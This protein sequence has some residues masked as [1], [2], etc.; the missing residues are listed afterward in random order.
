MVTIFDPKLWSSSEIETCTETKRIVWGS[1][2]FAS[3]NGLMMI[4]V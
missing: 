3:N 2:L 4:R 1:P